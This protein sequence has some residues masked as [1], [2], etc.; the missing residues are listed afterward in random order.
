MSKKAVHYD[1]FDGGTESDTDH[2]DTLMCG[3]E[4]GDPVMSTYRTDVTC[5][6]CLKIIESWSVKP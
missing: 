5:K 3:T 4:S 1:D 6:R 2:P